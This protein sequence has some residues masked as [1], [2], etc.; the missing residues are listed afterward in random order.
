MFI[1]RLA[2]GAAANL[3]VDAPEAIPSAVIP[4]AAFLVLACC[5]GEP[6][7]AAP[8]PRTR[9]GTAISITCQDARSAIEARRFVGWNGLPPDCTPLELFGIPPDAE[10]GFRRLGSAEARQRL[11][12]LP[13]YYRPLASIRDGVVVMLDGTNPELEG[14]WPALQGDLGEPAAKEDFAHGT[15][16]IPR[17]EWIYPDRGITVFVRS[18][19]T[20]VVHVAVYAPTTL[21]RYLAELRP[22]LGK[23]L[24]PQ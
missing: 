9:P 8:K 15:Y 3:A 13:G 6:N 12:E 14:G 22:H 18:D 21:E 10:L 5:S 20:V 16:E 7:G 19:A 4:V 2:V 11:L 17:G 23:R 24:H 1:P